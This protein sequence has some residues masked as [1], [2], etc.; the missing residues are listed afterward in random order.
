MAGHSVGVSQP[1]VP[2]LVGG[3]SGIDAGAAVAA[4]AVWR[5]DRRALR[6]DACGLDPA[7]ADLPPAT[8]ALLTDGTGPSLQTGLDDRS[9]A[10]VGLL[11]PEP[12][13]SLAWASSYQA[14]RAYLDLAALVGDQVEVAVVDLAGATALR[15]AR[16]L[17]DAGLSVVLARP[18]P[19]PLPVLRELASAAESAGTAVAAVLPS[20]LRPAAAV[21][22]DLVPR[23]APLRQVTI[24]GWPIGAAARLDLVDLVPR[25]A[26]DI[27]AVCTAPPAMPASS[28]GEG[29]PVTL[30]M[31]TSDAVTILVSEVPG[32]DAATALLT[33]SGAG[34]RLVLQGELVRHQDAGG[35]RTVP[36]TA[37]PT[38]A[39]GRLAGLL[40]AG[41]RGSAA[42]VADLLAASRALEVAR[43]SVEAGWLET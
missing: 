43:A 26:G 38:A 5:E 14:E 6:A 28:L 35:I 37:A 4:A 41:E 11:A 36:V 25:L 24:A 10:L 30:A 23:V 17:T 34:G 16:R 9:V 31:L 22:A 20:R 29:R 15:A 33:A 42:S 40:A 1:H 2:T 27:V 13:E 39:V 7:V 12:L 8:V 32:G 19:A 3:A 21:V 18:E